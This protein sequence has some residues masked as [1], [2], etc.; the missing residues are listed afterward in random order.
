VGVT[1]LN[2]NVP[3][4]SSLTIPQ[5]PIPMQEQFIEFK[6]QTDKLKLAVQEALAELETLKKSLMQQYFG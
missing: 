2:L 1:M 3:I 6:Q 5:L 4:V